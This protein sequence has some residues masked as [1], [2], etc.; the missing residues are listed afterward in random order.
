MKFICLET[1]VSYH[2]SSCWVCVCVC[3]CSFK[4]AAVAKM[5]SEGKNDCALTPSSIDRTLSVLSIFFLFSTLAYFFVF[6]KYA[7][8]YNFH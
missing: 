3:V 5:S 4:R 8:I 6:K 2:S 7:S 1:E